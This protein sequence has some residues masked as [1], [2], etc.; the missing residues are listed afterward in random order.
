M[1]PGGETVRMAGKSWLWIAGACAALG[2]AGVAGVA[3]ADCPPGAPTGLF[4]GVTSGTGPARSEVTLNLACADGKYVAQFFTSGSDFASSEATGDADHVSL[5]LDARAR[6]G[7]ADFKAEGDRLTG[8]IAA[9]VVHG[10][11][12]LVRAGPAMAL[13][14]MTPTLRLSKAQ[15]RED[16]GVFAAELPKRHAN[17]FFRQTKPQFEAEVARLDRRIGQLN[18]DQIFSELQRI[19][20]AV[21]DGHT[22]IPLPPDRRS[23]PI[24]IAR[25][26]QD[27][28]IVAA[29]PGLEKALGARIVQIGGLPADGAWKRALTL[30]AQ[31]ELPALQAGRA[32]DI[33][34][35]GVLLHGLG[36]I[37]DRTHARFVLKDDAGKSFTLD[38][39]GLPPGGTVTL[40]EMTT[41]KSLALENPNEAFWCR[42]LA[43][44]RAVYCAFRGYDGLGRRRNDMLTLIEKTH[45]GKLIIDMRDNGGGDNTLGYAFLI[46]PLETMADINR[47]GRLYVLVGALTFSAA[48][49]NAAQFQDETQAILVGE[50]IGEKP[51]SYQEPR[52]FR[53][54]NSHLIVRAS[55]LYY[56]FRQHGP[57]AVTPDKTIVPTWEDVKAGRDPALDWVLA[58]PAS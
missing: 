7:T 5:K 51:N 33:L 10:T 26:G 41:G 23:L 15:W 31:D 34:T 54:P 18:D 39:P 43:E 40:T 8:S 46:K 53:L 11:A 29:G 20:N 4:K 35:Q 3:A 37:P 6:S 16:L 27:L 17:A 30:T 50:Q 12:S 24:R 14:A 47:K 42:D 52:Q 55:S 1:V 49:N 21:G 22:G 48:M 32:Q 45:P 9:G 36:I 58:Q 2:I 25:F 19:T 13:D 56:K 28:H 38:I 44:R 57:N